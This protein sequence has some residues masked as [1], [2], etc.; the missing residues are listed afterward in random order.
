MHISPPEVIVQ[1]QLDAYNARDIDTFMRYWAADAQY[2]EHPNTL[3]ANGAAQIRER[4]L[5]RFQEPNLFGR[6][7]NRMVMGNRVIDHE[8]VTRTFVEG[9]GHISVIAI[10]EVTD[11]QIA[12]AWFMLGPRVLATY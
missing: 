11:D 2:F 3:L 7:I 9:A 10:Y 8:I 1:A 6:L 5:A 4:H 12:K